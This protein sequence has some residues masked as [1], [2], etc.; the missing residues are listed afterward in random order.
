MFPTAK[1]YVERLPQG[2]DSYPEAQIKGAVV[3]AVLEDVDFRRRVAPGDL[4]EAVERLLRDP[5]GLG[6]WLPE[7]YHSILMSS[8][9][10]ARFASAGGLP[11]FEAWVYEGNRKLLS[12][13]AYR[14]LFAVVS[15]ERVFVGAHK[16][17][18]AFHRGSSLEV[19]RADKRSAAFR[20]V[21]PPRLMSD[22]AVRG[23]SM[24]FRAAGEA[25]GA[26]L[27]QVRF[28][29]ESDTTTRY[30]AHWSE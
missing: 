18:S 24:A 17:W 11:A 4:P 5:P 26:K 22:L 9:F 6:E 10:D 27:M 29:I 25:A 20:L 15:P 3:R 30:D 2:I 28:E 21:Y 14:I 12:S 19:E 23:F 8:F 1:S 7:T 16:R 13:A